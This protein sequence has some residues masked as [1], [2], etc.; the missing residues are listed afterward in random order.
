[1]KATT[2]L[3]PAGPGW[4][5]EVKW[6]GM[7]VVA[8]VAPSGVHGWSANGRECTAAFPELGALPGSCQAARSR[9]STTSDS[10]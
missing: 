3:L 9:P 4:I 8:E 6:D 5:Y 1:M 10:S 2:G 7:R